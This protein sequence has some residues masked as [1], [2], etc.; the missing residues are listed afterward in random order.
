MEPQIPQVF[1][2]F[3]TFHCGHGRDN[4]EPRGLESLAAAENSNGNVLAT[5]EGRISKASLQV[6]EVVAQ[7]DSKFIL[8]KVGADIQPGPP[9]GASESDPLLILIDQHAADERCKVENLLKAYFVSSPASTGQLVAQTQNLDKP[10][11]FDLSKQDGDLLVRFKKHFAH[12][13]VVYETL[14]ER[15]PHVTVEVQSLPPSIVER[16]RLEPRLLIDLLRKEVWKLHETGSSGARKQADKNRDDDDWVAR[17]HD[18]PNG[19][20]ELINSR[21]CRSAIMFNDP[22]TTEQSSKLED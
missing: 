9:G 17:F 13:G 22:L 12:W 11:R 10:L 2:G 1:Q 6:A 15:S 8:T 14:H 5:L 4:F 16:C 3:N 21:A 20:M 18:C 19:I 7:V